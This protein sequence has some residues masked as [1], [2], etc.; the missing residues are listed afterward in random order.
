M[1]CSIGRNVLR[2]CF[3]ECSIANCFLH[4]LLGK[5]MCAKRQLSVAVLAEKER[6]LI[7]SRTKA[8]LAAAKAR[9]VDCYCAT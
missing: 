2:M 5:A 1:G 8:A 7:S 6:A 3:A 4:N 9:A